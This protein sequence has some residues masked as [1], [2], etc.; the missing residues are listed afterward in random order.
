MSVL[1]RLDRSIRQPPEK[2][3]SNIE[4]TE[5]TVEPGRFWIGTRVRKY[6]ANAARVGNKVRLSV[7]DEVSTVVHEIG[8]QV[9]F[10]LPVIEWMRLQ[11]I[12]RMRMVGPQLINIYPDGDKPEPAFDISAMPAFEAYYTQLNQPR[13]GKYYPAKVYSSGDTELLSLTTSPRINPGDFPAQTAPD[14]PSRKEA[15]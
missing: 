3:V 13:S 12:L 5:D 8:H 2:H 9:E 14:P 15:I 10:Y 1:L 11:Q 4:I 7:M 6:R